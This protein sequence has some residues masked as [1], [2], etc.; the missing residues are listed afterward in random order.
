MQSKKHWAVLMICLCL[1]CLSAL[2]T[3]AACGKGAQ[4]EDSN[5]P[6]IEQPGDG[7]GETPGAG[8]DSDKEPGSEDETPGENPGGGD[9]SG[10]TATYYE[11]R[12]Y[13]YDGITLLGTARFE[14]T[15]RIYLC[16]MEFGTR[17]LR[18]GEHN[19]GEQR[20]CVRRIFAGAAELYDLF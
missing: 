19:G 17:R 3:F 9:P 1:V 5:D 20:K 10:D 15:V 7:E 18:G 6:A 16:G 2:F 4:T 11:I 13:D 8:D 14:S 12:F